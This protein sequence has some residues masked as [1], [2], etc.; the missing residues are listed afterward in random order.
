MV[1]NVRRVVTSAAGSLKRRN[2]AG[3]QAARCHI[4]IDAGYAGDRNLQRVEE[5][6]A[7]SD[8]SPGSA[9]HAYSP[10]SDLRPVVVE[11]SKMLEVN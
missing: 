10:A 7:V 11:V 2:A 3:D 9:A 6:L 5:L 1:A 8:G 4:V